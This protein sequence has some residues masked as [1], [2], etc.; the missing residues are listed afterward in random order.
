MIPPLPI[1]TYVNRYPLFV[2]LAR[3]ESIRH[4]EV[5]AGTAG[6]TQFATV[7]PSLR[8]GKS[9]ENPTVYVVE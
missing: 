3:T 4:A 9:P 5:D 8:D 7:P 6:G 1:G 2:P